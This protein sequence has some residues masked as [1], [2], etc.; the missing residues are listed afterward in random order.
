MLQAQADQNLVPS[1]EGSL[2][3]SE[4]NMPIGLAAYS[5]M[6]YKQP[7]ISLVDIRSSDNRTTKDVKQLIREMTL[8]Q[9][10]KRSSSFIAKHKVNNIIKVSCQKNL[11]SI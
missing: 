11:N 3:A 5:R 2:H 4:S 9:P 7:A 1:I 6:T 8:V 10:N